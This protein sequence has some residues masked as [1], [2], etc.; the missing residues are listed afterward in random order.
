M[1]T[2]TLEALH[3]SVRKWI[4]IATWRGED[5]GVTNCPLC[6]KFK[7]DRLRWDQCD[8]CP[9]QRKTLRS[10][11]LGTPYILWDQLHDDEDYRNPSLLRHK[12]RVFN[13][14]TQEA[15]ERE[16]LFL[17]SLLPEHEQQRYMEPAS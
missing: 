7:V 12:H 4:R 2:K 11:C 5:K 10:D 17:I 1:E 9:V 14:L 15:A 6:Q 8:G 3:G 13:R 16:A